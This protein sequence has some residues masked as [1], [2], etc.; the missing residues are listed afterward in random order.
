MV[1]LASPIVAAGAQEMVLLIS[2]TP[3]LIRYLYVAYPRLAATLIALIESS[4]PSVKISLS[5]LNARLTVN[6]LKI[7]L[8]MKGDTHTN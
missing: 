6:A 8:Q 7:L 4:E 3:E 2:L 5:N 1:G